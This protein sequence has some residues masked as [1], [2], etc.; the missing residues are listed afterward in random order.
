ML[1]EPAA[2]AGKDYGAGYKS[3][4]GVWMFLIYAFIYAGFVAVNLIEPKLME[5]VVALGLNL[6]VFYGFFLIAFA[7]VMALV[8][9]AMCMR[10]EARLEALDAGKGE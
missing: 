5:T 4:L 9:N 1:H 6:A 2:Q 3:R 7:L 10:Q 8:Y